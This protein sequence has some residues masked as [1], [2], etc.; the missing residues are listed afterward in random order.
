MKQLSENLWEFHPQIYPQYLWIA[1]DPTKEEYSQ[2]IHT[3]DDKELE[4]E[5]KSA[6]ATVYHVR[7]K[8]NPDTGSLIV[9]KDKDELDFNTVAH[10]AVHVVGNTFYICGLKHDCNND[11]SFAY[12]AGWVAECCEKIKKEYD[13]RD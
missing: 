1:V 4:V 8:D 2:F 7:F 6:R 3:Y 5:F 11:E 9:F 12:L 10:E 13:N